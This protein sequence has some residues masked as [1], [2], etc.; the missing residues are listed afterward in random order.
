MKRAILYLKN[1]LELADVVKKVRENFNKRRNMYL[2]EF[3]I[4]VAVVI[5]PEILV[6]KINKIF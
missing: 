6:G 5:L 1:V 2:K 4:S 3:F